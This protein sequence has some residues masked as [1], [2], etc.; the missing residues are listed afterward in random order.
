MGLRHSRAWLRKRLARY[1]RRRDYD[2]APQQ[3]AVP[4]DLG[5]KAFRI[6]ECF[7]MGPPSRLHLGHLPGAK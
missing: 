3:T 7:L 6:S 1:A 2:D 5:D 4:L